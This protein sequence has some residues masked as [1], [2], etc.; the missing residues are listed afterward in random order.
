MPAGAGGR[1][2]HQPLGAVSIRDLPLISPI[3]WDYCMSK[4]S[5]KVVIGS[6]YW[7]SVSGWFARGG[8][9]SGPPEIV[10]AFS[11]I[12]Q[13]D[14][15]RVV[16]GMLGDVLPYSLLFD[17]VH[18]PIQQNLGLSQGLVSDLQTCMGVKFVDRQ[19]TE[20]FSE[21]AIERGEYLLGQIYRRKKCG[22]LISLMYK[23]AGPFAGDHSDF[24]PVLASMDT[25]VHMSKSLGASLACKAS[26]I[27]ALRFVAQNS[28]KPCVDKRL[29][30]INR[31]LQVHGLPLL[32]LE[33]FR[34]KDGLFDLTY[35]FSAM[36]ELRRSRSI[37][38]FRAKITELSE[39]PKSSTKD[40]IEDEVIEDLKT[41]LE[42]VALSPK[43]IVGRLVTAILTDVIG[44]LIPIAGTILEGVTLVS[45]KKK[46]QH[47]E[48]RLFVFEYRQKVR[49]LRGDL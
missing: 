24:I 17:E 4:Q 23:I 36:E 40:A 5:S 10:S 42:Q 41:T 31:V 25:S 21:N 34:N 35:M 14:A 47:L 12:M 16:L 48:W 9:I 45:E 11:Q 2:S 3:H 26:E 49:G 6:Y 30:V 20:T 15:E 7:S 1:G 29:R 46:T 43:G 37:E 33:A 38:R 28:V 22:Q 19:E 32:T 8:Q 39:I 44:I 18:I 27:K 13:K